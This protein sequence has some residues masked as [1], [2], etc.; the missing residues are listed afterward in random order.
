M[1]ETNTMKNGLKLARVVV[2]GENDVIPMRILNSGKYPIRFCRG[3]VLINI[4]EADEMINIKC[5]QTCG[6]AKHVQP[7]L[8][9]VAP[10]VSNATRN[11]LSD[12]LVEYKDIFSQGEYDLGYTHLAEHRIDTG[13]HHAVRQPLRRQPP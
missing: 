7:I 9:A 13:D 8:S 3:T 10:E 6:D 11:E 1:T 12:L 5:E 2:N 4:S